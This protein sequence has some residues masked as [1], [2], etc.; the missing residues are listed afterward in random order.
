MTSCHNSR[1]PNKH[2]T[3]LYRA[4]P[5]RSHVST[6]IKDPTST[7]T[8]LPRSIPNKPAVVL[9]SVD[10][11]TIAFPCLLCYPLSRTH[12]VWPPFLQRWCLSFS[13]LHHTNTRFINSTSAGNRHVS[14][15]DVC[16]NTALFA[17]L[18]PSKACGAILTA[19]SI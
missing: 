12:P 3:P 13:I 18:I 11:I 4:P 2:D 16:P 5:P 10:L 15:E 7:I 9:P 17:G 6:R 1:D 19:N 8:R 14:C